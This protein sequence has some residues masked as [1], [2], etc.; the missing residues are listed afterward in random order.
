MCPPIYYKIWPKYIVYIL[1]VNLA[2]CKWGAQLESKIMCIVQVQKQS[3]LWCLHWN[4]HTIISKNPNL[5][6]RFLI[7]TKFH[8]GKNLLEGIF[9]F[10]C[11]IEMRLSCPF[12]NSMLVH[13]ITCGW[14]QKKFATFSTFSFGPLVFSPNHF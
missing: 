9:N 4:Y 10:F 2:T 11:I 5:H 14:N 3:I 13:H 7:W 6:V 12:V 1:N 8:K